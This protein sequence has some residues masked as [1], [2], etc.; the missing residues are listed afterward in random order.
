MAEFATIARPYAE[1][2]FK[3]CLEHL[4][5][6]ERCFTHEL[7]FSCTS[8]DVQW[9]LSGNATTGAQSPRALTQVWLI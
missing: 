2:L 9:L 8:P 3:S 6:H 1:A 4:L 5:D 7:L